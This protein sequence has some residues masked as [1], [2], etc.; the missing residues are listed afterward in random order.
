MIIGNDSNDR[1]AR[2]KC[3]ESKIPQSDATGCSV[4][5]NYEMTGTATQ[6][7]VR[8][9]Y[10]LGDPI[11]VAEIAGRDAKNLFDVLNFRENQSCSGVSKNFVSEDRVVQIS[12][13]ESDF[14]YAERYTCIFSIQVPN[15]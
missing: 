13:I 2:I 10:G 12:C 5:I 8:N 1:V 9:Q 3:I 6:T 15:N 4:L 7:Y 11:L 14:A